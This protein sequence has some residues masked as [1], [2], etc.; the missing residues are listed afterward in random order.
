MSQ[1]E[2]RVWD[3]ANDVLARLANE[4]NEVVE[5]DVEPDE[6]AKPPSTSNVFPVP[7]AAESDPEVTLPGP[8]SDESQRNENLPTAPP[9]ASATFGRGRGRILV[10]DEDATTAATL[11]GALEADHDVTIAPNADSACA[12]L[13]KGGYDVVLCSLA[14]GEN[15]GDMS[16]VDVYLAGITN[17]PSLDKAFVFTTK[18]SLSG[19]SEEFMKNVEHPL[20]TVPLQGGILGIVVGQRVAARLAQ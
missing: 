17:D 16:G 19:A 18:G 1:S 2:S 10:I 8:T 4:G 3:L 12:M 5:L 11:E 13:A 15:G 7:K 14:L 9:P 6:S 20:I